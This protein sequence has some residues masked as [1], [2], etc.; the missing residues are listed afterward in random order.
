MLK[1][2]NGLEGL[3]SISDNGEVW[4]T[5][6]CQHPFIIKHNLN[7]KGYHRVTLTVK[8]KRFILRVHRLVAQ[9][10][11]PN[12]ENKPQVN[13]IDGNKDNNRVEN[14]EW[15]TD[16]ENRLHAIRNNLRNVYK[17]ALLYKNNEIARYNS[18]WEAQKLT[19]GKYGNVYYCIHKNYKSHMNKYKD[20]KWVFI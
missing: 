5:T 7:S 6:R 2:I 11:I 17:V 18:I 1:E 16:D 15:V 20:Y 9:A 3:Y 10:F 4:K 19:N 8:G 13:H 14:L 12:P